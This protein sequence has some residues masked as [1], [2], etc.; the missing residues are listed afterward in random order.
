MFF[1]LWWA[2]AVCEYRLRCLFDS[3]FQ[4]RFYQRFGRKKPCVEKFIFY[5]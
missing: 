4:A 1:Y 3:L 5:R 2:W